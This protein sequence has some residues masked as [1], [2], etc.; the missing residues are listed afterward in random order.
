MISS[1]RRQ[2]SVAD[3]RSVRA[4]EGTERSATFNATHRDVKR[5]RQLRAFVL[6]HREGSPAVAPT[7]AGGCCATPAATRVRGCTLRTSRRARSSQVSSSTS[8]PGRRSARPG[9]TS[10]DGEG[11][12][13]QRCGVDAVAENLAPTPFRSNTLPKLRSPE[14]ERRLKLLGP[15]PGA[16]RYHGKRAATEARSLVTP[17]QRRACEFRSGPA[18]SGHRGGVSGSR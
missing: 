8:S 5:N 4:S 6:R 15:A 9:R 11:S 13:R 17:N 12:R 3:F 10:R 16:L 7:D 14:S 2:C 1:A 18:D